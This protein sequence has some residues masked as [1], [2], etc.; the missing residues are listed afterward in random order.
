MSIKEQLRTLKE[1]W[2][3]IL[4]VLMV[5]LV[6]LF[7]KEVVYSLRQSA[8]MYTPTIMEESLG[9]Q[10]N[11]IADAKIGT[12]GYTDSFAQGVAERKITTSSSLSTE[13][14]RGTF[15]GA[16]TQLKSIVTSTNSY[17]LSESA[18]RYG[19]G[20]Q[21][22]LTGYYTIKVESK[23]YEV[24]AEQLK[25]IGK[26]TLFSQ[27]KDDIT[28]QY[29][30]QEIELGV[31]KQRL[32]RYQQMYAEATVIVDKIDLNDR[33]FEQ[34]RRVKYLED[35]L[36]NAD[37]R[38]DYST[39]NVMLM[40]EQSSYATIVWVKFSNL[41]RMLVESV[42]SLLTLLFVVLPYAVVIGIGLFLVRVLRKK[43]K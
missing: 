39:I 19:E 3:L 12:T 25:M 18:S 7:G 4:L 21:S 37:Q 29:V 27:N 32:L 41:V 6:P 8:G 34:E 5:I 16:E 20:R 11:F 15:A 28:E 43:K 14:K 26:V 17:F 38:V 35:A 23:K 31:E 2:L 30:N 9:Y 24:I 10:R 40:E 36:R 1:N 33:I 42:N 13:V 22:Y